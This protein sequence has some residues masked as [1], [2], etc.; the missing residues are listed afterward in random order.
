MHSKYTLQCMNTFLSYLTH[1]C[2]VYRCIWNKDLGD[3]HKEP[4]NTF[5]FFC[6]TTLLLPTH[7]PPPSCTHA[8]SCDPMDCC[9]PGSSVHGLFQ[10]RI[11][12][13]VAISFSLENT[14]N[15]DSLKLI[16]DSFESQYFKGSLV[17]EV[18]MEKKKSRILG[19]WQVLSRFLGFAGGS[20]VKNLPVNARDLGS[21]PGSGR[22]SGEGNGNPHQY[23]CLGNPTDRADWW[24]TV[25]ES[26][27]SQIWLTG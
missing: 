12:E 22:S 14:F 9:P 13:W 1:W 25:H 10:A 20:V 6:S 16:L 23:P 18:I 15:L 4:E 27:K 3:K 21:I 5:F 26:Q 11:L 2:S 17:E 8:Q 24:A 7:P 19:V